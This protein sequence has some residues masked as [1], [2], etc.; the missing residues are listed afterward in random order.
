M[1][2]QTLAGPHQVEEELR[3]PEAL[4]PAG[5]S[6][7]RWGSLENLGH[8]QVFCHGCLGV[9]VNNHLALASRFYPFLV[10]RCV[11]RSIL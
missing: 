7:Q 9:L 8:G 1:L 10:P 2:R 6:E 11:N 4:A 3:A 5:C